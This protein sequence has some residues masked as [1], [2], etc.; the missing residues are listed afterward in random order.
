MFER[1]VFA[2][3]SKNEDWVS[4]G[5][6][7]GFRGLFADAVAMDFYEV[8][9][10]SAGYKWILTV[11]D[12]FSREVLFEPMMSRQADEVVSVLLRRVIHV[13]G[14]PV[15]LLSD[16]AREFVG[17]VLGGLTAALGVEHITTRAYN[18][19]A[20]GLCERVLNFWASV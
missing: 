15:L 6:F 19:R 16:E 8:A 4:Y 2:Y 10:S 1:A 20:N 5:Q 3:S 7:R 9:E 14:V 18:P 17:K 12:M 11:I 13:K